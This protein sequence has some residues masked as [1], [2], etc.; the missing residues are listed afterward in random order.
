M[1]L[2][3]VLQVEIKKIEVYVYTYIC[4]PLPLLTNLSIYISTYLYKT[5]QVS[6][7]ENLYNL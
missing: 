2:T 3:S 1:R 7:I 5:L 4:L 6:H